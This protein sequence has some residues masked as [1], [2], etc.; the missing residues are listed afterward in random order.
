M[1]LEINN[2]KKT[3]KFTKLWKLNNTLLSIKW[4]KEEITREVIK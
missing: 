4:I 3:E 1:K 2:I